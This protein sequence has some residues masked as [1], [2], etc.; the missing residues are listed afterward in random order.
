MDLRGSPLAR[1]SVAL[2]LALAGVGCGASAPS[3]PR[4]GS[5]TPSVDARGI[6]TISVAALAE[7]LAA[8][9]HRL[10]VYDANP[11]G[12]YAEHH[13]PSAIWVDYDGVSREVLPADPGTPLV[14]YCYNEQCSAAATAAESAVALG[15]SD[16]SVMSAGILGWVRAGEPIETAP[17]TE[18]DLTPPDAD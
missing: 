13:V 1:T 6:A 7:R 4:A 8:P 15:Y 17:L 3:T 9:A 14:F 5:T 12:I 2:A 18:A 16:V 11:R 10:A